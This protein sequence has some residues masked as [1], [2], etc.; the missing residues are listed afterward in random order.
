MSPATAPTTARAPTLFWGVVG[1]CWAATLWLAV[2]GGHDLAHHDAVLGGSTWPSPSRLAAFAAV[3]LLMIGAMMLPTVTPLVRMFD[4][5]S[6]R[7]PGSRAAR[8]GLYGGYVAVWAAFV[9]L[10]LLGD[11]GVH[12]LVGAWSWLAARTELVLG[13]TLVLAG[14]YQFSPLK[15]ACLTACRNPM[16]FLWQHYR[17]GPWGGWVLGVR[18]GLSCLG[19]CWALMLVMFSTGVGSLAW[20]L[21]LT[22]V[23]VVEKTSRHG[24]RLVAPVGVALFVA[25]VAVAVPAVTGG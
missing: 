12:A 22:G 4:V 11:A 19:C 13:A 16:G 23:M 21:A 8:A 25:G 5:V 3:W 9:P 1:A 6:A 24:A 14:A 17:R 15:D 18:H 7:A 20:M 2:G 10:A